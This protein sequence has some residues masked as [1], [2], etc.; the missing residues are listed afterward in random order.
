[1]GK[2]SDFRFK[3]QAW[4]KLDLR[5]K[6]KGFVAQVKNLLLS[7]SSLPNLSIENDDLLSLRIHYVPEW[8]ISQEHSSLGGKAQRFSAEL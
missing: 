4:R 7:L 3:K 2:K 8:Q 6:I 5:R 1:M